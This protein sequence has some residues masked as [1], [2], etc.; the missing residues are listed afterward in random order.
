LVFVD[1]ALVYPVLLGL[2]CLGAGLL[3]DRLGGGSLPA[4]LVP[5]VGAALLVGVSQWTTYVAAL[6][7]GTPYAMVGVAL[8]GLI[9]G[10]RRLVGWA[11]GWRRHG[12][13]IAA[14]VLGYVVAAAPVLF[15]GRVTFTAYNVLPDSA[16]HLIGAD[17][18]INHGQHY[19]HLDLRNSYGRYINGY[20]GNAY[21]TGAHTLFGGSAFLLSV[22]LIWTLQP[23]CAFLLALA[24]G[25]AWVIA[26]RLGLSGGWAAAAALTAS[27]PALVYGYALIASIKELAAL[28]LILT[29]GALVVAEP[30]PARRRLP[31]SALAFGL[32]TA[33]GV[34]AIGVAFG[35]WAL[36][37]AVVLAGIL[38]GEVRRGRLTAGRLI[39]FLATGVL[40]SLV[41][42]W[43][44]WTDVGRSLA[45]ATG[46]ATTGNSGNLL[47]PLHPE[48]VFGTWLVGGYSLV[49]LGRVDHALTRALI[50]VTAIAAG[51][52]GVHLVRIRAYAVAGWLALGLAVWLGL[53]AYGETWTDAKILMLT[54]PIVVLLAWAGVAGL[55]SSPRLVRA[56]PLVALALAGG[57]LA[58]DAMQYHSTDLAPTARYV[59]LSALDGRFGGGPT[60]VTD[61]DEWSLYALR[62][63]DVGGPDFVYRPAGLER[64]APNHGDPVDL[65][66]VPPAALAA[67]PLIITGRDPTAS[68]PP[69]AY[70]LVWHGTYY[71]VW[72]RRPRARAALGHV[73]RSAGRPPPCTAI[74][75]LAEVARA[76]GVRLVSAA[77]VPI[78]PIDL[79]RASHPTWRA[80]TDPRLGLV[81]S[82][83]GRLRASF[84]LARG[85][86]WSL[87]IQG[88]IMPTVGVEVDGRTLA[89]VGGQVRGTPV[90]PDTLPPLRVRLAAGEHTLQ[91]TRGGASLAPG[92]RGSAVLHAVFLTPAPAGE[93]VRV[94]PPARWRTLC[95]QRLDWVEAG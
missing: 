55:R 40:A 13:P 80:T 77:R 1:A 43:P 95:G 14:L 75:L 68:R 51:L 84:R 25:P 53:T 59:E 29:L 3:V 72:R 36:A 94:T 46:I 35:T 6:A 15:A 63:L 41:A 67:Y 92:G 58:S 56:A 33:A 12:W 9:A 18:L 85:G 37:A 78:L 47:S 26:R 24:V 38:A 52:G 66:L 34:S 22:P 11:A 90:N 48:Q 70:R 81:M 2:L 86:A 30:R 45:S 10:R 44:T 27:M 69:A 64:I 76:R 49:P 32:V 21:P 23:F 20:F 8:A 91:I 83:H 74:G 4:M 39:V 65:D 17:Y 42:A 5:A 93:T 71:E 88:E 73:G 57:V 54:S 50:A 16:L 28:P 89:A 19:A 61:F 62:R 79:T 7:P 82:P 60:L 87:W 31:P